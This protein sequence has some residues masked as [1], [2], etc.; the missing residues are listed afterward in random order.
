LVF[1]LGLMS[2]SP[3]LHAWVHH[4][5]ATATTHR[6]PDRSSPVHSEKE[7]VV[8]WFAHGVSLAL[9]TAVVAS[10]PMAW[11]KAIIPFAGELLLSA[12]PYRLQPGRGPPVRLG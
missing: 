9:D 6:A 1:M 8:V 3:A 4:T 12:P 11:A 2:A 10:T 7:C 5:A